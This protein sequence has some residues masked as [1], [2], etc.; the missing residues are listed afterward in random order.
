MPAVALVLLIALLASISCADEAS[1]AP[2]AFATAAATATPP[3]P[4]GTPLPATPTPTGPQIPLSP[5]T[6]AFRAFARRIDQARASRD[7]H[8]FRSRAHT[9]EI[10]CTAEN[11]PPRFAGG[12]ACETVGQ[13]FDG[14][15]VGAWRSEGAIVPL[16]RAVQTL[17]RIWADA[18]PGLTDKYGDSAA[19]LYAIGTGPSADSSSFTSVFTA[20][21]CRPPSFPGPGPV[22]A[23][24]VLTWIQ[25]G[26]DFAWAGLLTAYVLGEEFLDRSPVTIGWMPVW[27]R[28]GP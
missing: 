27:E 14:F 8:F 11:T 17:E 18:A 25:E 16:E 13:R 24:F 1:P 10:I 19:Q 28:F 6:P 12:A 3:P 5:V 15:S 21:V 26:N 2:A 7:L 9:Q 20:I 22:R 4:T 23:V